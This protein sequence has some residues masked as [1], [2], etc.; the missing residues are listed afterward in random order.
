MLI[1]CLQKNRIELNY[2]DLFYHKQHNYYHPLVEAL[3]NRN[4][5][6]ALPDFGRSRT[7]RQRT[8]LHFGCYLLQRRASNIHINKE[9]I[10]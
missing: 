9:V 6:P 7:H 10:L 2:S 4:I 8:P 1:I 3:N 5:L